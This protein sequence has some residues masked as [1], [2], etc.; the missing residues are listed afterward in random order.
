[1]WMRKRLA[2]W[3]ARHHMVGGAITA[4]WSVIKPVPQTMDAGPIGTGDRSPPF[5]WRVSGKSCSSPVGT[6]E[7]Q[8]AK[9]TG[10]Q[11]CSLRLFLQGTLPTDRF[12][13]SAPTLGIFWWGWSK[14]L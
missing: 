4:A 13:N 11:P 5:Q 7:K 10:F 1:M 14:R 12:L 6:P 8:D 2:R 3:R 9:H